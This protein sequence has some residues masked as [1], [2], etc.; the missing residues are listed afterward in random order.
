MRGPQE[1]PGSG[2]SP[3]GENRNP[4]QNSCLENPTDRG[5]WWSRKQSDMTEATEDAG[6]EKIRL[7]YFSLS[8]LSQNNINH[9]LLAI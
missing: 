5:V 8:N 3:R 7:P 6:T 2:K 9:M 1:V 4:L